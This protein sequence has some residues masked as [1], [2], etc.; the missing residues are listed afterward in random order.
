VEVDETVRVSAVVAPHAMMA[1]GG[2]PVEG[3]WTGPQQGVS[4]CRINRGGG[5]SGR[6]CHQTGL[7]PSPHVQE[8]IGQIGVWGA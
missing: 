5:E 4:P 8:E 3:A 2:R 1:D 7:I 6:N